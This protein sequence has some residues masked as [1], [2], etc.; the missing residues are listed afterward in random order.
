MNKKWLLP[1]IVIIVVTS[2]S[3]IYWA[4]NSSY[5]KLKLQAT[6]EMIQHLEGL[7]TSG[8]KAPQKQPA[9]LLE[10]ENYLRGMQY[11]YKREFDSAV[12]E[13]EASIA[14]KPTPEAYCELGITLMEKNEFS[15]AID[16]LKKS[17]ELKAQ[18]SKAEY[19]MA[20]CYAR[21][22][23]PDI[24]SAKEHLEK[25]KKSG[26]QIPEWFEKY[27]AKLETAK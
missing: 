19:A 8:I 25:A 10:D 24:K 16:N 26:Y 18:Y 12:S 2:L 6:Q 17:I 27:L 15:K 22:N 11:Y 14:T 13:F 20:V 3:A 4:K 9:V 21:I 5:K 1:L 7:P 23:P